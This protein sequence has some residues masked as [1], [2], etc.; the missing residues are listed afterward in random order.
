M[1]QSFELLL[2][3]NIEETLEKLT[4]SITEVFQFRDSKKHMNGQ[5]L[6]RLEPS[7]SLKSRAKAVLTYI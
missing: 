2:Q 6:G 3:K 7:E 4:A 1:K 5:D